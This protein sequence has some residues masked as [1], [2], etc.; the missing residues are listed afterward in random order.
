M[1]N[2]FGVSKTRPI[3]IGWHTQYTRIN[4]GNAT[5][6]PFLFLKVYY[7]TLREFMCSDFT[8]E[9]DSAAWCKDRVI[10]K[11]AKRNLGP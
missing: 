8:K 1:R 6:I 10:S 7:M 3:I 5:L 11:G 4:G 2:V 9:D